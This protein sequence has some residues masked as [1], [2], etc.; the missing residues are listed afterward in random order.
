MVYLFDD[1]TEP[2]DDDRNEENLKHKIQKNTNKMEMM[3]KWNHDRDIVNR[4]RSRMKDH[5][6]RFWW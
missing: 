2:S 3:N 5:N 6:T 4:N 1:C